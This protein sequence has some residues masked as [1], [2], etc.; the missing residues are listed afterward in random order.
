MNKLT[1]G[2]INFTFGAI[3]TLGTWD[4]ALKVLGAISLVMA[5]ISYYYTIKE[6]RESSKHGK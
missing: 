6:K 2:N 1:F 4:V 3:V 5:I